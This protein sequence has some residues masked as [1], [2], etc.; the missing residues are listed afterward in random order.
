MNILAVDPGQTTGV[1]ML[2]GERGSSSLS[3]LMAGEVFWDRRCFD[4][5]ALLTGTYKETL[6]IPDCIVIENFR[7]R[8]GRA[9][10]QIGSTFP[11]VEVIGI[12]EGL[13]WAHQVQAQLYFQEPA[14]IARVQILPE[15]ESRLTGEHMKDAYKHGRLWAIKHLLKGK[16]DA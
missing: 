2:K 1:C 8:P 3:L 13:R 14:Q 5:N 12:I 16:L 11:S 7:L 10:Q 9:L 15:H 6:P 4:F